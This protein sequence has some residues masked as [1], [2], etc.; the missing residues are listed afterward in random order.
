MHE[1]DIYSS[2]KKWKSYNISFN[3]NTISKKRKTR[4]LLSKLVSIDMLLSKYRKSKRTYQ[5]FRMSLH[6][7]PPPLFFC[8]S[9]PQGLKQDC[10]KFQVCLFSC[11]FWRHSVKLAWPQPS[12]KRT[13]MSQRSVLGKRCLWDIGKDQ[14]V[15]TSLFSAKQKEKSE[16]NKAIP[17]NRGVAY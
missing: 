10:N 2:Y 5:N 7:V 9:S 17:R 8:V 14:P 15:K 16:N 1:I 6:L 13:N 3:K 4:V 11:L 12:G